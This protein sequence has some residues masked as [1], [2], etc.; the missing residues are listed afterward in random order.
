MSA[1]ANHFQF[2]FR[3]GIRSLTLLSLTYLI[4]L[5]LYV[6]L[7]FVLIDIDPAFGE[8]F[9]PLMIIIAIL[10]ATLLGL[11][12]PLVIGS[13]SRYF[14]E[15][16]N[17]R[18]AHPF[19][20]DHPSADH[21]HSSR[22]CDHHLRRR[23]APALL[24]VRAPRLAGFC[25]D[26]HRDG[27]CADRVWRADRRDFSQFADN[28]A[29]VTN[30]LYSN[31]G[32]DVYPRQCLARRGDAGCSTLAAHPRYERLSRAGDGF[33]DQFCSAGITCHPGSRRCAGIWA[34]NLSLQLGQS[35]RNTAGAP[36]TGTIG[37]T[38]V[39]HRGHPSLMTEVG[40]G[41]TADTVTLQR[42]HMQ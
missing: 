28:G 29:V 23:S 3:T 1:F 18:R 27:F 16:Q 8:M 9:I 38:P 5:G 15:L 17:Q 40:F 39:C 33:D 13:Q 14:S 6:M 37:T 25:R 35:K 36:S 7:G 12:D 2:E 4:P 19:A 20:A 21:D 31:D 34:G 26:L 32:R 24:R 10:L 11:P 41:Q 22:D 42:Y 30:D